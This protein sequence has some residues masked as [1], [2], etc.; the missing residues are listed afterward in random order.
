MQLVPDA[1]PHRRYL[2]VSAATGRLGCDV[3]AAAWFGEFYDAERLPD[4]DW[5]LHHFLSAPLAEA[6]PVLST[7]QGPDCPWG[8]NADCPKPERPGRTLEAKIIHLQD[9]HGLSRENVADW[10]QTNGF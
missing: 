10:L 6:Y 3:L 2:G 7:D 5:G 9:E 4:Q 8:P 1:A